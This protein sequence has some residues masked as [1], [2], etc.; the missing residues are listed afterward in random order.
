MTRPYDSCRNSS[1]WFLFFFLANFIFIS[2]ALLTHHT[3]EMNQGEDRAVVK[4]TKT[5]IKTNME[6]LIKQSRRNWYT[7]SSQF[8]CTVIT[9]VLKGERNLLL[10][11]QLRTKINLFTSSLFFPKEL[12]LKEV[13]LNCIRSTTENIM[14]KFR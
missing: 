5:K 7:N 2:T 1:S 4:T 8:S 3:W 12:T 13:E 6:N 10:S 11:F 14:Q 9:V